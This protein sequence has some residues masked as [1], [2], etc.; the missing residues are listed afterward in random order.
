MGE[1]KVK[2]RGIIS[3]FQVRMQDGK[4]SK[5][6][7]EEK[8]EEKEEEQAED[9]SDAARGHLGKPGLRA[10]ASSQPP[11]APLPHPAVAAQ[12]IPFLSSTDH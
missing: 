1:K 11:Q 4:K 6:E 5:E 10:S 3:D 9:C 12:Q 7:E 8:E 2:E